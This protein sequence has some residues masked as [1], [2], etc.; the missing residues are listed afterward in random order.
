MNM[1]VAG[2]IVCD[3]DCDSDGLILSA[4]TTEQ[5]ALKRLDVWFMHNPDADVE[6]LPA[7]NAL[8]TAIHEFGRYYP[9]RVVGCMACTEDEA[10]EINE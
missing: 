8:M 5:E 7:T 6:T 9:Y 3:C 4:G 10:K 1:N 2:F